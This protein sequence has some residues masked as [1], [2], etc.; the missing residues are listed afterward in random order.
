M[1]FTKFDFSK[2]FDFEV[3]INQFEKA[4]TA[5]ITYMPEQ[6]RETAHTVNDATFSLINTQAKSV[7]QYAETVQA[8]AKDATA[9][10]TRSVEKMTNGFKL[11]A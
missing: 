8:L 5:A 10:F 9:E 11:T 1:E 3:A 4:S 2:M 6:M 7:K